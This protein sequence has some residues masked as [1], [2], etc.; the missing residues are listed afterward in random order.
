M[1]IYDQLL[2]RVEC[3]TTSS[4]LVHP[5]G[6][7]QLSKLR[8]LPDTHFAAPWN[9]FKIFQALNGWQH[10]ATHGNLPRCRTCSGG[11]PAFAEV[12][13]RFAVRCRIFTS[14]LGIL[15]TST[16]GQPTNKT[17]LAE[18]SENHRKSIST[19]LTSPAFGVFAYLFFALDPRPISPL[20]T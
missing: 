9:L 7:P 8:P 16:G 1:L 14:W 19:I 13:S 18:P 11:G 20:E 10:M 5:K 15:V 4:S 12:P 6:C 3:P 2:T 17:L